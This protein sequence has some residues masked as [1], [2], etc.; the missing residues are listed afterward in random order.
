MNADPD[1]HPACAADAAVASALA[2]LTGA[3][4]GDG[5][6]SG[7]HCDGRGGG[8]GSASANRV[9]LDEENVG[10][11]LAQLVLTVVRLVHELL[12]RQALRRMEAG[13]LSSAEIERLGRVLKAQSEEIEAMAE[14]FGLSK[15]DLN[16]D[17]GPLGKAL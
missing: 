7:A 17:L 3:F 5:D 9:D 11:G 10:R 4:A 13:S 2:E 14:R 1:P 16:L 15:E 6:G 12:E 8:R